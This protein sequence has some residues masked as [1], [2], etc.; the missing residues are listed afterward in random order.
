MPQRLSH[1]KSRAEFLRIAGGRRK[2]AH[3]GLVLQ[4]AEQPRGVSDGARVGYTA[5]RKV[6]GAVIRNRAKR[7]LRAAVREVL[8]AH[9]LPDHDYVLIARQETA[10]LPWTDLLRNLEAACR[11]VKAWR[12][13]P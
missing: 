2:S 6:G 5:S 13:E 11:R 3:A 4:V 7:R 1:L 12:S 8:A 9:A 10:T